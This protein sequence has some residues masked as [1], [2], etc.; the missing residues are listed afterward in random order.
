MP[1]RKVIERDIEAKIDSENNSDPDVLC[2]WKDCI[3]RGQYGRCFLE[4]YPRCPERNERNGN[5]RKAY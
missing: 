1:A 2:D 3:K 5:A 4:N